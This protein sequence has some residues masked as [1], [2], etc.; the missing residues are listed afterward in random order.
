MKIIELESLEKTYETRSRSVKAIQGITLD[1]EEGEFVAILG[2]SGSGKSTLI[3]LIAGLEKP[4]SGGIQ[5]RNKD[6]SELSED[7]LA[8]FRRNE[9]G[10]VFQHFYLME[11]MTALDNVQLP[12]LISGIS[13]DVR[14][15]RGEQLLKSVGMGHRMSH[16]PNEL[17]GGERQRVGIARALSNKSS[18]VIADEPTGDLDSVKGKEIIDLLD[19]L[20]KGL[21]FEDGSEW[22][23]T[24]IM[25]THDVRNLKPGMRVIMLSD[26]QVIRDL[27]FD[28]RF[29]DIDPLIKDPETA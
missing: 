8:L 2:K 12:L 10:I 17:S 29:S 27:I 7:D 28:G 11:A 20:N 16:F 3:S 23:P 24:V 26:G 22:K 19:S 13:R 18:I 14:E 25:V 4:T 9:I 5:V 15:A 21:Q 1:I 6:L